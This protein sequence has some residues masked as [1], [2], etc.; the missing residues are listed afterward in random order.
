LKIIDR[1]INPEDHPVWN[2]MS[3]DCIVSDTGTYIIDIN[4]HPGV[5]GL[6]ELDLPLDILYSKFISDILL[7]ISTSQRQ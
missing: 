4:N 6:T 5:K 3:V 7:D 2:L 1:T